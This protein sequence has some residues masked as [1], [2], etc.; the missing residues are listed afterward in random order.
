MEYCGHD[1]SIESLSAA[2]LRAKRHEG[3]LKLWP[4]LAVDSEWLAEIREE[5][6]R[7]AGRRK[8]SEVHAPGHPAYWVMPVGRFDQY[9][10]Y[11]ASGDT[12]DTKRAGEG[13]PGGKS[14][15][16]SESPEIQALA[17]CFA[18]RLHMFRLHALFPGANVKSH[19][20]WLVRDDLVCLRFIL[21]LV[22]NER[23]TMVVDEERFHLEPGIVY[24]FNKG[25]VHTAENCGDAPRYHF[26]WDM[27]LDQW[28]FDT[29][30]ARGGAATPHPKLRRIGAAEAAGLC[31]SSAA[32]VTEY[33]QGT[34]SG[35]IL[36]AT[37]QADSKSFAKSA[38]NFDPDIAPSDESI[39]LSGEW[40]PLEHWG[41][42]TYRWVSRDG[43]FTLL[44]VEDGTEP[45]EIELEPGPGVAELP[46]RLEVVDETGS[47]MLKAALERRE[48]LR[49]GVPV[50][51][52]LRRRLRVLAL[53]GGRTVTG[54]TRALD[55]RIFRIDRQRAAGAPVER[56][57]PVAE[58]APPPRPAE[59]TPDIVPDD[60]SI[61]LSES[62]YPFEEWA[63]ER[64]RWVSI[65]G[66]FTLVAQ[67]NGME[68][69]EIDVEPGPG[70]AEYPLRLEVVDALGRQLGAAALN[71]R[72]TV[73]VD[74]AVRAGEKNRLRVL[75]R[76]GGRTV[77]GD[78]RVL[79][80][81]VFRMEHHRARP[82][83]LA[84]IAQG[85][86]IIGLTGTWHPLEYWAGDTFRWVSNSGEFTLRAAEDGVLRIEFDVEPGSGVAKLPLRL[87]VD[88]ATGRKLLRA[89][90]ERR[91]TVTADVPV[92]AGV[93]NLLR[94]AALNGGRS[95]P[96][97]P[98][99]L[100]FRVFRIGLAGA[101]GA[102]R[103]RR[104]GPFVAALRKAFGRA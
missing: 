37:R 81:R 32:E 93:D 58:A 103:S 28:V 6:I 89:A 19:E 45:L 54:E 73:M 12:S 76:N 91:Q 59:S 48:T 30:F 77:P 99:I 29:V 79:D 80:F 17:G 97:D 96:A 2:I 69:L 7:L 62:W 67:A 38:L 104:R 27:W 49:F 60:N 1:V 33:Y 101:D 21:P 20:E 87:A 83:T 16:D 9:S 24:Y 66:E 57:A 47:P 25:C 85:C 5:T 61:V 82:K 75:A 4:C 70:V 52:G 68:C 15:A 88:D 3:G 65:L 26:V 53:N 56:A 8:P 41:G 92:R 22:T 11:N 100:D 14:F 71:R 95:V 35:S 44:G 72:Q 98:R 34:S 50:H 94:L 40:Q 102:A 23:A 10:L 36:H 43:E 51:A 63:G 46:L 39:V 86:D 64:F 78:P 84:D 13:D 74:V 42:D 55:F 90:V 18:E 31:A